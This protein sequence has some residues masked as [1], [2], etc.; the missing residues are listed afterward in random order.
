LYQYETNYLAGGQLPVLRNLCNHN[1]LNKKENLEKNKSML[2]QVM[3][4]NH[5]RRRLNAGTSFDVSL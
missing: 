3:D 1:A 4:N 2:E 5:A